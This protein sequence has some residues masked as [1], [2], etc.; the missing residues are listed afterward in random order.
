MKQPKC[1]EEGCS[2]GHHP[3]GY[4]LPCCYVRVNDGTNPVHGAVTTLYKEELKISN[5]NSIEEIIKSNEWDN[6]FDIIN[7]RPDEWPKICLKVCD[8]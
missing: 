8:K 4:I 6:F 5:V 7:N 2:L 1:M 3:A